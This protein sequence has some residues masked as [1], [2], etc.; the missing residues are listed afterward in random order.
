MCAI[1]LSHA[2]L[3]MF[4]TILDIYYQSDV[5]EDLSSNTQHGYPLDANTCIII[6]SSL[7]SMNIYNFIFSLTQD[8]VYNKIP[9]A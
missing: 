8:N 1:R 7:S 5:I 2:N 4:H 9:N 3:L 6:S